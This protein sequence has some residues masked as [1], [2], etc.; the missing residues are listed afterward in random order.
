RFNPAFNM[1]TIRQAFTEAVERVRMPTPTRLRDLIRQIRAARTA[2][3]ER[4]VVNKECAYI[5]S[6]FREEDSVWRCRNIAKLLYIHMLGYPAHFGQLEC[7]KL[8]ASTRF[9]DKRIGYL[10]AMLLLDER[11]DVHL[12]ITN[13]LKNDLNSSTQFV[14]GLALCTL[15]AIASPEMARDLASE[16]ER[17]MKSPN[18]YIRKKAT[19]CAFRVI[20][21][22]PELMEIF[23]PATRS[24]LSEKNHGILITGVTLITEMCEN[25]SDTLM[26]FKKI[27]PNLVRILKS[28]ILGGY[29]P[30]HDVSGVSDPFLQVKI[31]RLLR[32]LGHN[33]PDAS[34]AMND[35]L[36]QVATNTE[37]S[38]NVGNTILYET[39]LSIMDIRSEGGLRV[40]AVNILGR[41]LLNSDKNIRYVALNTLLRTVHADTSAVQRHRTTILECLKDPD[42]SIRRRAMELSFALIN[43]QNIRTMTKELLLFLEKADAEFKAQCSSGM[44]LAAE[45]Y[46]PNSRWHLDTQLSVL[47]AAGNYVRDD[48]VSSTIQLV[49]SSPVPEQTYITNRFWESLQVANH[50]EDKQPLLQVAVWAIGEYGDLFMYGANE[51]E[52]ERPT[53]SDLI[54]VYH[55]FLT[56]AQV[57]TTS[58]QYALVSLAKLS[59]RLQQCVEEIQALITS[60]GS[61]LNVD[62]QQRGVEFTQLFGSYKHLRPPLLEK[63]P[64]MQISRISSQNGESGGSFDDNSPDVIENGIEIGGSGAHPLIESNMNTMGDNTVSG[65]LLQQLQLELIALVS[66]TVQNIL[67]DLLGSTDLSS[68][69]VS[70]LTMA[71]DLSNAV[72]KKNTRNAN[73]EAP[74]NNQDLLDLLDLDM[75]TP[76]TASVMGV[77][78][79]TGTDHGNVN[80]MMNLRGIDLNMGFGGGGG[81]GGGG[82]GVG[83]DAMASSIPTNGN[84]LASMLGG[85]SAPANSAVLS[86]LG[87]DS[88]LGELNATTTTT[89]NVT[90]PPQGP[91]LTALDKNGLLV[92]LVPVKGSDCMKIF[93]T[94]TN[95]SDN[96]LE[97]YLLKAAVQKSFEL[98]MLP[99]SGSMLPPGG[100][101]TQEMRVVATSNA[102]LRMRLRIQYTLD[103]QQLVEQ[104]EV[105]GFPDQQ[106]PNE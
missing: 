52:F 81:G 57:S 65:Q 1:A 13:C 98:Q 35:I 11:Q 33:D 73:N 51:D 76:S 62:L 80:N 106:P 84:D 42:V 92:Q 16:V 14:V 7:L 18:T 23:L 61:H 88:L 86:P 69:G 3:E 70:D 89:N 90:V 77:N 68:G 12:L 91:K 49:S 28:L 102:V 60:F 5:R 47:I 103:G 85:L 97:Q 59:T 83:I 82:L 36:A 67:L 24:L 29:S 79:L 8:T 104:T 21:R 100:V 43:A 37:T 10:G 17:L 64:A 19:L 40:L 66:R 74:S 53:E 46:S 101:I 41:F 94:T 58:K 27:V 48:V 26:H 95:S 31:L 56:S 2:A 9:T 99:P 22:V 93:M 54:A 105:S 32:I 34:E 6:T 50:C 87:G 39:V 30:E 78:T 38:K 72:H 55:K 4:A 15:G 75:T 63:M 45:R 96:T 20:R 44:I 25:S 71:T